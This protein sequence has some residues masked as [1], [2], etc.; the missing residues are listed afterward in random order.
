LSIA[1]LGRGACAT[2]SADSTIA[3]RDS[4]GA[5]LHKLVGHTGW[6]WALAR[7][8]ANMLAS[9]SEDGSVRLW[10]V[11]QCTCVAELPGSQPLRTIDVQANETRNGGAERLLAS[12][13]VSGWVCLWSVNGR[14]SSLVARFQA[15]DAAIRRVR[16]LS[17]GQLA[18]CGEDQRLCIWRLSDLLL[19]LE[20]RRPNF[21]TDMVEVQEGRLL[22]SGYEGGLALIEIRDAS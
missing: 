10:D 20:R 1:K 14:N 13:D 16:F 4:S 15:H 17:E 2:G 21:V 5:S 11:D 8:D 12:G 3:L 7:S 18:T 9:A 6:V 19:L 22:C